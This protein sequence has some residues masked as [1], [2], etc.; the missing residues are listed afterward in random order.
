MVRNDGRKFCSTTFFCSLL[1]WIGIEAGELGSA[2]LI[3]ELG[4][5]GEMG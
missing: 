4:A 3:W 2:L 5:S 1:V